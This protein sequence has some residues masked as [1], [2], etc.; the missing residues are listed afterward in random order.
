MAMSRAHRP[1]VSFSLPV[2]PVQLGL[3]GKHARHVH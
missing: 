3:T 1:Y 2:T